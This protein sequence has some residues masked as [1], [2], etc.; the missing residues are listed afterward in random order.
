MSTFRKYLFGFTY[1]LLITENMEEN[2]TEAFC[3]SAA[4]FC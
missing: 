1:R 3:L 4:I 2:K